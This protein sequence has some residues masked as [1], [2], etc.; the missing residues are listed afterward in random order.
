MSL[1][2][3]RGNYNGGVA[4]LKGGGEERRGFRLEF[5]K[6]KRKGKGTAFSKQP[7]RASKIPDRSLDRPFPR[8]P[9][10]LPPNP[11]VHRGRSR[12]AGDWLPGYAIPCPVCP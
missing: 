1:P 9:T 4:G 5:E 12:R 7:A 8:L 2:G 6:E 10:W 3:S 11:A